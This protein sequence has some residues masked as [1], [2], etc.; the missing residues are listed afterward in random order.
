MHIGHGR[1]FVAFD[2]M[3]R[4]LRAAGYR[5]TYVRNI[6]DIDDKIIR[7]AA[8][9]GETPAELTARFMRAMHEDFAALGLAQPDHEPRATQYVPQMLDL[10]G[11]LE[12]NGL[13]YQAGDGDVNY[14]VRSFP[15]Y[16]KLSRRD[17]D[18]L[19]PHLRAQADEHT[20]RATAT[21]AARGDREAQEIRAIIDA[22]RTR[23]A[24]TRARREKEAAQLPLFEEAARKQLE[25]DARYWVKRLGE[26]G[27]ELETEP[28]RIR[29]GY[30]V[31]ASRFEP[32]GLVYLWP[33]TG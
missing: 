3:Q 27:D 4:W 12:R 31:R 29:R 13:A 1:T 9:N 23:I 15:G 21:L 6:T 5:V 18:E 25:A 22:Q 7:R 20:T 11:V 33:V 26:L 28:A 14:A 8:E 32:V 2:V 10:I 24:R 30:E 16:G 19:R 17:L